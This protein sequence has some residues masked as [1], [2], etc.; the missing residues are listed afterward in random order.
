[1][2]IHNRP[3]N[4]VIRKLQPRATDSFLLCD[5]S[6]L[7]KLIRQHSAHHADRADSLLS[8]KNQ[9]L[10]AMA[11]KYVHKFEEDIFSGQGWQIRDSVVGSFPNIPAL[12]A[13]VPCAMRQRYRT[14]KNIAPLTL[15]VELT[16]SAGVTG[17]Q[18]V[19]RGAAMLALVR[20]LS[21]T[22]PVEL[23]TCTTYGTTNRLQM[24][25]AKIETTP[26]DVA[27]AAA[28]LCDES[29]M[30]SAMYS[31]NNG[32]LGNY[33]NYGRASTGASGWAYGVPDLERKYAGEILS[34][35][36]NPGSTMFYIPAASSRDQ[37]RDPA[38]WIRT[39]LAK[40]GA[41]AESESE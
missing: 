11:E 23:W 40:Y 20:L 37:L 32:A 36:L 19:Q 21:N 30:R 16:G 1:M 12:L 34:G 15:Y 22:R 6:E 2:H 41:G 7:P 31:V 25:A 17:E 27:R 28:M 10:T 38:V 18:F 39:M 35:I 14:S 5:V 9:Q 3:S 13:G 4:E 8:G 33:N 26:L 29:T 24:V